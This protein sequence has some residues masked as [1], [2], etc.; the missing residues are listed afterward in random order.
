[1]QALRGDARI[2]FP[3][4]LANSQSI[5]GLSFASPLIFASSAPAKYIRT[6]D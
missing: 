5:P 2:L 3:T 1:M 4:V 6:I